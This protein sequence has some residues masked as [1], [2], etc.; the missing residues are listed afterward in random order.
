MAGR[1]CA[2]PDSAYVESRTKVCNV[3]FE[4]LQEL[5]RIFESSQL[6]ELEVEEEG[7]R[8]CLK[9][10]MPP[11]YSHAMIQAPGMPQGV[12]VTQGNG[13]VVAPGEPPVEAKEKPITIDA[14]MVGTFYSSPA[15]GEPPFVSEGDMVEQNQTVCIVEAMKLMNEVTAKYACV[16][17]KILLGNGEPVEFGQPLFIVRPAD[18]AACPCFDGY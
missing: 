17:E 8:V 9:K 7:R 6:A 4:N 14:P 11:M 1:I 13:M 16:I 12:Y 15:P 18:P 5:I 2:L 10:G 3:D